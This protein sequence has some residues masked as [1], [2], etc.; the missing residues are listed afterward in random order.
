MGSTE[1][2]Y[3][4]GILDQRNQENNQKIAKSDLDVQIK[5]MIEK[6]DD[7]W[8]CKVCGKTSSN[9]GN[10]WQHTE[11][12]IEGMS[13]SCHICNK[14]FSNR[15]NVRNHIKNIHSKLFSCDLCG[16]SGM[17]KMTFY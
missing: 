14:S 6:S 4:D 11:T 10:M 9:M 16:K 12:H 2:N 3:A 13:H 5:Q 15:P 17:N 1:M 8:K 7:V